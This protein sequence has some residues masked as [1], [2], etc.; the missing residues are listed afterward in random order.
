MFAM[1]LKMLIIKF[2]EIK[3]LDAML[4]CLQEKELG[5]INRSN[6]T[7]DLSGFAQIFRHESN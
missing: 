4:H 6:K 1:M 5:R 3:L 2:S 7:Y